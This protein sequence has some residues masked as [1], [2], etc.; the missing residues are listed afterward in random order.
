MVGPGARGNLQQSPPAVWNSILHGKC[1]AKVPQNP[2]IGD[3]VEGALWSAPRA[4]HRERRPRESDFLGCFKVARPPAPKLTLA[5]STSC[6]VARGSCVQS[7]LTHP[8]T[9]LGQPPTWP[10]WPVGCGGDC[11]KAPG[12]G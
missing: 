10:T 4:A 11:P 5:K 12:P 6:P 9:C 7:P 2:K 3:S 8:T 1:M